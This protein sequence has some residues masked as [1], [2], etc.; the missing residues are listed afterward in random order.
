MKEYMNHWN[1]KLFHNYS[2]GAWQL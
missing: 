2:T 1:N